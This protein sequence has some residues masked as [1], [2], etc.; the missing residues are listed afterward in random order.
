MYIFLQLK[1]VAFSVKT[2]GLYLGCCLVA[3]EVC[4]SWFLRQ[5]IETSFNDYMGGGRGGVGD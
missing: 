1:G 4:A 5:I 3:Y 2:L